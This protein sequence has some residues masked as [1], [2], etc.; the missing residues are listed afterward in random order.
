MGLDRATD[1]F[2]YLDRAF[3]SGTRFDT[4]ERT[5]DLY[6]RTQELRAR[7]DSATAAGDRKQAKRLSD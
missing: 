2:R 4:W 7:W 3:F 6:H 5:G 1:C